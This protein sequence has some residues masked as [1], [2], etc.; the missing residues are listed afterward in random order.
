MGYC[1]T[2]I[3]TPCVDDENKAKEILDAI[4][5]RSGYPIEEDGSPYSGIVFDAKWYNSKDDLVEVSKEFPDTVIEMD[6]E[7]KERND[8]WTIRVKNG[9][10]EIVR[11]ITVTPPFTKILIPEDQD[12]QS[13]TPF[14]T[15]L[16]KSINKLTANGDFKNIEALSEEEKKQLKKH[17]EKLMIIA[18]R[19]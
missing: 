2:Y 10:K 11:A 6:V 5:K 8:N 16:A 9:E 12:E 1:S 13:L 7:G 17:A 14:E 18:Y 3:I 15:L 19:L 4:E